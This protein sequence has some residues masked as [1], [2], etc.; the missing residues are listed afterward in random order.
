[1]GHK[2]SYA[3][4]RVRALD[5]RVASSGMRRRLRRFIQTLLACAYTRVRASSSDSALNARSLDL[6]GRDWIFKTSSSSS[7]K[8]S[9]ARSRERGLGA[10]DDDA[11]PAEHGEHDLRADRD[12]RSVSLDSFVS[13]VVRQDSFDAT[14]DVDARQGN[15]RLSSPPA[16]AV[17]DASRHARV[18]PSTGS[19]SSDRSTGT[20]LSV[21]RS[22]PRRRF[23]AGRGECR[24]WKTSWRRGRAARARPLGEGRWTCR[25]FVRNADVAGRG[26]RRY[27]SDD[28]TISTNCDGSL[29]NY[30]S[31]A[32]GYARARAMG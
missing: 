15:A 10:E 2:F 17:V 22:D 7:S 6:V 14:F 18:L 24:A 26:K 30:E 27:E 16:R 3:G 28:A 4:A 13:R 21:P 8:Y 25:R 9:T 5:S 23:C 1:M 29:H 19:G 31:Y 12:S 20:A 32:R 11:P